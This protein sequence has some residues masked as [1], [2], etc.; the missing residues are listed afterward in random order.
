MSKSIF[1]SEANRIAIRNALLKVN[2]R[3]TEHV[4][5]SFSEI[6][7]LA[8]VA[9]D[10]LEQLEIP[11]SKRIGALYFGHSGERLASFDKHTRLGTRVA[12]KRKTVGWYLEV[13]RSRQVILHCDGGEKN[14]LHI[15]EEQDAIAVE[16]FRKKYEVCKRETNVQTSQ[17]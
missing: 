4:F 6:Q 8:T 17:G 16:K 13:N 5:S 10:E 1:I 12:L 3:A 15:S 11:R 7:N 2:G 14:K 9:E